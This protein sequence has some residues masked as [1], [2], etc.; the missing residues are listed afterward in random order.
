MCRPTRWT[1]LL[2]RGARWPLGFLATGRLGFKLPLQP[3]KTACPL[4]YSLEWVDALS[5]MRMHVGIMIDRDLLFKLIAQ[6]VLV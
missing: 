5:F 6:L 4:P 2:S 3:I 1:L